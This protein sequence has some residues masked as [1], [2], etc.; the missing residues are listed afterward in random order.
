MKYVEFM[1]KFKSQELFSLNEI[2]AVAPGF[3]RARLNEWQGK[4]YIRKFI[5]NYYYFTDHEFEERS[6]F[7]AAN[8]VY[9]PS[10]ISLQSALSFYGIIPEKP[11]SVTSVTSRKTKTFI[12]PA[13]RLIYRRAAVKHFW[14]YR[15]EGSGSGAFLIAGPAKAL[16]DLFYLDAGSRGKEGV[17]GLRINIKRLLELE[18]KRSILQMAKKFNEPQVSAAAKEAVRP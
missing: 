4:G 12:T 11:L 5:R 15:V 3:Y 6:L 1:E 7:R 17:A 13:A 10:Y 14:G 9:P 8:R 18:T 16:L 2:R